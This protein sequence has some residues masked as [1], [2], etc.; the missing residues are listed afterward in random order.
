MSLW[1]RLY[2]LGLGGVGLATGFALLVAPDRTADYFVWAVNPPATAMFMGAGYLGTG[3]T[4]L[5][6]L[7]L[8]G[9]WN[10]VRLLVPPVGIFALTMLAATSL[11]ADRFFWDRPQTWLWPA[12]YGAIIVGATVLPAWERRRESGLGSRPVPA[13][14]RLALGGAGMA[15]GVVAFVLFFLPTVALFIWPWPLTPLTGRVVAGWVVVGAALGLVGATSADRIGLRVPLRGWMLTVVFFAV[16]GLA[17]SAMA[18]DDP[19]TWA[20]LGGL[21]VSIP[22]AWWALRR[23]DPNRV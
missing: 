21:G 10:E 8:V 3:V 23:S 2:L 13:E 9:T 7:A 1:T 15:M 20:Y 22:G 12:L 4:V 18:P 17:S 5:G 19:R 14:V 16:A 11:H 6:A